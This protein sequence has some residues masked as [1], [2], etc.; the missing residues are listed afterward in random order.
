MVTRRNFPGLEAQFADSEQDGTAGAIAQLKKWLGYC[1]DEIAT[2][3]VNDAWDSG[4]ASGHK[5]IDSNLSAERR[6][7][8]ILNDLS[9]LAPDDF[10]RAD[11]V[12]VTRTVPFYQ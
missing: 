6:R 9:I 5:F 3:K 4:D 8:M 7:D 1:L 10:P 11:Y 2:G 12:R